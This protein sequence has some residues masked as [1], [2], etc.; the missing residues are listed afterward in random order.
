MSELAGAKILVVE[1]NDL[2]LELLRKV[3]EREDYQVIAVP[4]G[5]EALQRLETTKPDLILLDIG[6]PDLDGRDL[7][8]VL[9]KSAR[10]V[11]IPVLVWSGRDPDRYRRV[12]LELGAEDYIEKGPPSTLLPK[13]ERILLRISERELVQARASIQPKEF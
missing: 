11:S 7:L 3:L 2:L 6:L 10:T 1:D 5:S 4:T 13:I 8:A 12:A 9:K